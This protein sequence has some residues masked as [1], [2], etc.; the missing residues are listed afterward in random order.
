MS[1]F[2]HLHV[3]TQYSILDGASNIPELFE[4]VQKSGM[5]SLAITDHGNMFGVKLFHKLA[6]SKDIKPILGCEVYVAENSRFDKTAK[7]DRSGRH[8]VLLAKN[9]KGYHNLMKLVS[10]GWTEGFYYRPRI[11]KE[12][13]FQYSE[14]LIVSTACLAG[15]VSRAILNDNIEEAEKISLEY[16]NVFGEDFYLELQ[17]HITGDPIKDADTYQHQILVNK[18]ILEIAKKHN[19]KYIATNDVHYINAEDAEAH[20]ILICLSTGKDLDDPKRMRYSGQEFLKTPEEMEALFADLPEAISNTK[21][22]ADKIEVYEL[23]RKPI[24]PDFPLPEGFTSEAEYLRYLT[25]E[26]AKI[27]WKEI[28]PEIQ[29]RID[30]ELNTIIGMGF[31]GYFLIVWDFIRAAREMGVSVGPGRGSAAGSVVAYC[32]RITEMD[33]IK[34]ELLFER[35]LNPD[36]ISMPD[37]DIDFDEDGREKVLKWVVDK[38]GK[39]RVANVITFGSMAAKSSIKDVARVQKLSLSE[40]DRLSKMVPTKPGTNLKSAFEQVPELSA[41]LKSDNPLIIKTL[42]LAQKLE[43]SIRQT[44]VHA[45]GIIIGRDDLTNYI[46]LST[47]KDSELFVTQ[48]DGKHVEDVG[49]L[50][51][52]FLGLT[53]LSIIKDAVSNI[54]LARGTDVDIDN[55][56]LDDPETFKLFAKGETSAIFQFE[57]DGMKKHLKALK[58]TQ[59]DDLIAMNALYRPG[60]MDYIPSFIA[61]KNGHEKIEYDLPEMEEY[62]KVTYGVTVYQEQVMLLS[63]KLAGFTKG[64][65]DSLRKAMGKKLKEVMDKLREQFIDGAIQKGHPQKTVEKIWVDWEAF[66][67]Y[68]FNKS[69]STCYAFLAYQT[70]YLKAHFPAEFMAAVLNR[71][72]SKSDEIS[73]LMDECRRMN[74][75]VLGPDVNESYLNFMV[76]KKGEI[77]FGL[78]A[79]KGV[80]E[81]AVREII[82]ER[83]KNGQFTDYFNFVE[84]VNLTSVNKRNH[85][86]LATAGGFDSFL[87]IKRSQYMGTV[88]G[89]D[90]TFIEECINYGNKIQGEIGT[91]QVSM[92]GGSATVEVKKPDI[93]N[94]PDWERLDKLNKEKA[95]IG[96]Y[97]SEH[98]LDDYKIEIQSYC[99][100]LKQLRELEKHKNRDLKIAGII[101]NIVHATTKTGNPYGSL[102]VEDYTDAFKITLFGKDYLNFKN[103]LTKGYAVLISGKVQHRFNDESKEL[104]LKVN[105][106]EMLADVKHKMLKSISLKLP[107]GSLTKEF[108]N[109]FTQVLEKHKGNADLK[110]MIYEPESRIWVEM[111]SRN[112]RVNI[113]TGLIDF[114]NGN[115]KVEYKI[116]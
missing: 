11:D 88:P 75:R 8:L 37:I 62:L 77:R 114:L 26:A 91:S 33:P 54:R 57:S 39:N 53:T 6:K 78:A 1:D 56:P 40:S 45:C 32:L 72:L 18:H 113:S 38:Y 16:K 104:E 41:E 79:V 51:M 30:F 111:F 43:G 47:A 80:G 13:L 70:G 7:E 22:I 96:I 67:Q 83:D 31:P 59:F 34:Y 5:N 106:F 84:R 35:F 110:F 42:K 28:T 107:I 4:K 3:H 29:E 102:T 92:F 9:L 55:V 94:V 23:N 69:H 52:D 76:N 20:D 17:R 24:M 93:P 98:P 21:E 86:A 109:E 81:V 49:M 97:L 112:F 58:P 50:K 48:Y 71:N 103:Y 73:L 44:G 36:R 63:Q 14:G 100:E 82:S 68:A 2:T 89:S 66:A 85:E 25:Y 115:G 116:S 60:P 105:S 95:L 10:I 46:P 61:R 87:G 99:T 74:I 65:A 27:R 12:L 90:K 19:I 64:Q 15:P 101:T 108:I